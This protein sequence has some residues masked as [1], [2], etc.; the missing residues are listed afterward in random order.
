[1]IKKLKTYNEITNYSQ[2]ARRYF[3]NNF[4]DGMLTIMGILLG[5]LVFLLQNPN[6]PILSSYVILT[7]MGTSISMLIS[8]IS[9]SYLSEKAEQKKG[10]KELERAMGIIVEKEEEQEAKDSM[11]NEVEEIQKAMVIPVNKRNTIRK[12]KYSL[13]RKRMEKK[14]KTLHEKA[15][16]FT[17]IIVSIV[18]GISPFLGGIV[19][20]LPFF[21]VEEAGLTCFITSFVIIFICIIFLGIFLGYISEES[22]PKN[23]LQMV[24]AFSLTIIITVLIL[25]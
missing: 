14:A 8:G 12:R 24:A 2:I 20:I 17:G 23:I 9:G 1:M 16:T 3:V 5:F 22:I 13:K 19:A 25:G 7:G 4:Y 21:F 15:E 6:Q 18:N 11:E 10:R